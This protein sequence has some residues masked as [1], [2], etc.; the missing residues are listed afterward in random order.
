MK[1][2]AR[3]KIALVVLVAL[4]ALA[5]V[6][7]VAY[8]AVGRSWSVAATLMDDAVGRMNG[9]T[10][11][12][13][14]AETALDPVDGGRV[15]ASE[16]AAALVQSGQADHDQAL[17]QDP[18]S[19]R[20]SEVPTEVDTIGLRIMSYYVLANPNGIK[21]VDIQ[22]VVSLYEDKDT[23]VSILDASEFGIGTSPQ[24]IEVGDKKI[25]IFYAVGYRSSYQIGKI[26]DK[27][28]EEGAEAVICITPRLETLQSTSGLS[29]VLVLDIDDDLATGS[30]RDGDTLITAIPSSGK[31]EVILLSSNNVATARVIDAL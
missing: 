4:V 22:D 11:L 19:V 27:L 12:V 15:A 29:A 20:S 10:A 26:V 6:A 7:I 8:F 24:V 18:S 5:G 16:K 28:H 9:Y 21:E 30:T 3:E 1:G 14:N 13:F 17:L 31:V 23:N 25:G 2:R